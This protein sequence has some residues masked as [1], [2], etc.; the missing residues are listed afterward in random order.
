MGSGRTEL[1]EA[2]AGRIPVQ[3][4]TVHL[5]GD[6]VDGA[7]IRDRIERGLVL[8]P[9]DRQYDGLVPTMSVGQNLTLAS[10]RSFVRGLFLSDRTE[11]HAVTRAIADVTVKTPG[12]NAPITALSG[13]N[14]QKVVI[15]KALLTA[16]RVLL[17]DEPS[18]GVD[19]GAK[20]DVF[21]LMARQ[22][23]QGLAVLFT[24]SEAEEALRIPDRLLVLA[25]GRLV[26]EF[27]R[28]E[29]TREHLMS[30]A[31]GRMS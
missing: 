9:E 28:G 10:V 7:A 20:A 24:T 17:L 8:V 13:G 12:P 15:G 30:V 26:G 18:R 5:S 29:I 11:R 25:R 1:L 22:A 14:Q 23:E 31:D 21:A 16:P 4:G 19:V 6:P 3:R 27:A 2:I